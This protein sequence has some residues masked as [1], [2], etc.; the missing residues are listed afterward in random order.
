MIHIKELV[1]DDW[2]VAHIARHDVIPAEVEEVCQT[3]GLVLQ[4]SKGRLV[5]IAPTDA[6]RMLALILDLESDADEGVYYPV[7]ARPAARKERRL[8]QQYVQGG[9][10]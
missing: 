1:W 4:G 2:N 3:R 10:T 7:T 8:Y 6:G 5:F 9:Q